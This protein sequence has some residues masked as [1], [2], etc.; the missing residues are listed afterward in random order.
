MNDLSGGMALI[1]FIESKGGGIYG[2]GTGLRR[3]RL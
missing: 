2:G 3:G 1:R